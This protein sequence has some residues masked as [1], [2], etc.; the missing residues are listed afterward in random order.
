MTDSDYGKIQKDI[1]PQQGLKLERV[2]KVIADLFYSE[3]HST[4]TRIETIYAIPIIGTGTSFRRTFHHNK[5]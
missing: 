2:G 5:D 4:T 3:G 1:P